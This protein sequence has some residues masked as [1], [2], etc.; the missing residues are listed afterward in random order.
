MTPTPDPCHA[1]GLPLPPRQHQLL[2]PGFV[3]S[4][5]LPRFSPGRTSERTLAHGLWLALFPHADDA[6]RIATRAQQLC[7]RQ[8]L[9]RRL[10]TPERL[11]MT[12]HALAGGVLAPP[13]VVVDAVLDALTLLHAQTPLQLCFDRVETF[14]AAHAVV[15][16]CSA[17]GDAAVARL[18]QMLAQRLRQR[19]LRPRP[20]STPH[21]TLLYGLRSRAGLPV[22]AIP[23]LACR[24]RCITLVLSHIGATHHT[25]I[26]HWPLGA[27]TCHAAS[28]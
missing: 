11:H 25:W 8:A 12:L 6:G 21:M 1:A 17:D 26:R 14:D 19:Q 16:R 5:E 20:S 7:R 18:R 10:Q 2:L 23:P 24:M 9:H 28:P 3:G 22:Q 13:Q 4:A 15:L 27:D